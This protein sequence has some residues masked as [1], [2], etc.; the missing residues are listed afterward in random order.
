[1]NRRFPLLRRLALPA[2]AAALLAACAGVP[3][4]TSTG[5]YID[6]S[7]ITAKVKT[8]LVA[9]KSVKSTDIRVETTK[10]R[11]LLAG[12]VRSAAE[13]QH[14]EELARSV[15]GVTTVSNRLVVR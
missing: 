11:V 1:M 6:D 13:R 7:V 15:G 12:Y 3:Q 5:E 4:N 14:A 9:D 2:L 8:N 10:G